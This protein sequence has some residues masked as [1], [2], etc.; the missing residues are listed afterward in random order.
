MFSNFRIGVRLGAGFG[1]VV[2]ALVI[3]IAVAM[4]RMSSIAAQLHEITA[5]HNPTAQLANEL[6]AQQYEIAVQIR[7]IVM[8]NDAEQ[9][10]GEAGRL[11]EQIAVYHTA[12][13]RLA[14]QLTQ[15]AGASDTEKATMAQI[16]E[17]AR[18]TL[19]LI[20]RV[21][22]LGV[23][24]K[25]AEAQRVMAK[26]VQPASMRWSASVAEMVKDQQHQTEESAREA[27][28][29]FGSAKRFLLAVGALA[30]ALAA[31]SGW[32]ITVSITRP[33]GRA[34][35]AADGL[36][37]G[38]LSFSIESTSRDETGALLK[39][40]DGATR[41]LRTFV[42]QMNHMS[43]EHNRGDIDVAMDAAQFEGS[44]REMAQGV[45]DMVAGHI[46]LKKKAMACVKEFGE[47]NFDAPLEQFP[48]KKAF[49][50]AT[51]EQVRS[52]LKAL[53]A[54]TALLAEAAKEGR[55]SER[56]DAQRHLG[57]FR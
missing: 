37:R 36:A 32:L 39:A 33:L 54:D 52:N 19:L 3:V 4:S 50:N 6:R 9:L 2:A 43:A 42:D 40:V 46:A 38:D 13:A 7:D 51:V 24:N 30:V 35:K 47:G 31:I 53:M 16:Q 57:D 20:E 22:E 21:A 28:A 5:E 1:I 48:G 55:L 49:I 45:N 23:A 14:K 17:S 26:Q 44:Y 8:T 56:A 41:N 15:D 10:G 18:A 11:K 34:V 29:D 27:E 25:D 12:E